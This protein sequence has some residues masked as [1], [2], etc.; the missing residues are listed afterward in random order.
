[1]RAELIPKLYEVGVDMILSG[2]D[3][4]YT[5]TYVLK[6]G[7]ANG[8]YDGSYVIQNQN[9]TLAFG[10]AD[11]ILHVVG[12]T[13]S[14]SQVNAV[15]NEKPEMVVTATANTRML[16]KIE[17]TADSL[18]LVT[19]N[20]GTQLSDN[21]TEIDRFTITNNADASVEA[22]IAARPEPGKLTFDVDVNL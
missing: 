15:E 8:A 17:V 22:A 13:A 12:G 14:A 5:R 7:T 20:L 21:I 18:S 10:N 6:P 19:Y 1:M 11:G 16:S 2:H 4:C 9:E 3:H